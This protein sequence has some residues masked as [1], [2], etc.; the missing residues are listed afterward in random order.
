ME[1]GGRGSPGNLSRHAC[2]E[3]LLSVEPGAEYVTSYRDVYRLF[4]REEQIAIFGAGLRRK[5]RCRGPSWLTCRAN[6][7]QSLT[8]A[9]LAKLSTLLEQASRDVASLTLL[10]LALAWRCIAPQLKP[11]ESPVD[12]RNSDVGVFPTEH[13]RGPDL[14]D[15]AGLTLAAH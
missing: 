14:D 12:R 11:R 7:G 5:A 6:E 1:E 2:R 9:E 10:D 15:I 3:S 4:K 8:S 13:N